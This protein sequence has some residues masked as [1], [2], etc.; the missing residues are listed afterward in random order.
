[1]PF[2][3]CQHVRENGT[4]CGSGALKGRA[5]CYFHLRTRA[6]RLALAKA[7]SQEQAWRPDLPPLEDMHAVQVGLMQVIDGLAADA[8]DPHRG[9]L[10]LYG[11]QQAATNL[12]GVQTWLFSRPFELSPEK[13]GAVVEYPGLEAEF[14]L[15][16]RINLD[17]P[18]DQLFPPPVQAR[19]SPA[20]IEENVVQRE[21]VPRKPSRSVGR[22]K[23]SRGDLQK[24]A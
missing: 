6:R 14:G 18:A 13:E 10:M 5:Y 8:L 24:K 11:L 7:N 17:A 16:Q 21:E 4:L 12:R 3:Y 1:M 23:I 22:E 15:P 2:K 19:P 20:M 9:A